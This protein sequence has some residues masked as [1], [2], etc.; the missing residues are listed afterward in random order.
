MFSRYFSFEKDTTGYCASDTRMNPQ[1]VDVCVWQ[2][3]STVS[4]ETSVASR[5]IH[6]KDVIKI[7]LDCSV[8]W[9]ENLVV[10]AL[11]D[12][13]EF[14]GT[15]ASDSRLSLC[16]HF[17]GI[18]FVVESPGLAENIFIDFRFVPPA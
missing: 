6:V 11:A 4:S 18:L 15:A 7:C 9:I 14:C 13:L 5:S 3:L 2:K 8:P 12:V 1:L 10:R 17:S 16:R